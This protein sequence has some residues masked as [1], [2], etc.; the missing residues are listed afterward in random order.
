M[1]SSKDKSSTEENSAFIKEMLFNEN[2][3]KNINSLSKA[4]LEFYKVSK[5]I[6]TN[7]ELLINFGKK[8]INI[9]ELTRNNKINEKSENF[10]INVRELIKTLKEIFNKLEINNKSQQI[11]LSNF[12]EDAKIIFK[13]LREN[14]QEIISIMKHPSISYTKKNISEQKLMNIIRKRRAN[15][16]DP[17]NKNNLINSCINLDLKD[18]QNNNQNVLTEENGM[19]KLYEKNTRGKSKPNLFFV[20]E[21]SPDMNYLNTLPDFPKNNTQRN[22]L[23]FNKKEL[24]VQKLIQ[25]NRILSMEL[26]KY[27]SFINDGMNNKNMYNMNNFK[28]IN[29]FIKDKDKDISQLKQEKYQT[30][31][32]YQK[33]V[34]KHN[35]EIVQLNQENEQIKTNSYISSNNSK[36]DFEKSIIR[37]MNKL[38][39]ENKQLKDNIE[40]LKM[41]YVHSYV[42]SEFNMNVDN[43]LLKNDNLGENKTFLNKII[44]LE[45]K[46]NQKQKENTELSSKLINL[47]K[48]YED[49]ISV[50][51]KK[52]NELTNNLINNQNKLIN[53]QKES[54]NKN[55]IKDS[56][57]HQSIKDTNGM[58]NLNSNENLDKIKKEYE[59]K[60][61]TINK[62]VKEL[63][64]IIEKVK[65]SESELNKQLSTLKKQIMEK[66]RKIKQLNYQIEE[67]KSELLTKQAEN[68]ILSDNI[69]NLELQN[70][71]ND[72]INN[73]DI[74]NK[75]LIKEKDINN[76]LTEELN[77]IKQ[78]NIILQ[79][80][81]LSKEKKLTNL[82]I[83]NNELEMREKE[84]EILKNENSSLKFE[85]EQF[86]FKNNELKE[87]FLNEENK[88]YIMQKNENEGLKQMIEKMQKEREK[89]DNELNMYKRENEKIKNQLI[90]LSKTLPEEYNELQKQYKSLEGKYLNLK[91]KNPNNQTS[92]NTKSEEKNEDKKDKELL[93]A[94]KE[95]EQ[96]KKKN[97]E[98]FTQLEDKE[99]NKNFYDNRSEDANKS[100]YEEEFDLRKMAKGARDK[101]RSQDVNIDYPGLQNYKEK[102]RELE[103]YYNSLENLVKKL[104]LTIQC[105]PKNKTYVNE[106]CKIVGFD[107]ETTNKIIT[108]KNKNFILGLFSK[109]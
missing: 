36:S 20:D 91:N 68:Q 22:I 6:Y 59:N 88:N 71:N 49:K 79:N 81:L 1:M 13:R 64:L 57:Q 85:N 38:M 95:I 104:L 89:D 77:K 9:D 65:K 103:F 33:E 44:I 56:L 7:K 61:S 12:F 25:Q 98:L 5:N 78:N 106:L 46:L 74:L 8:E 48:K 18:F 54:L 52:Y 67:L 83:I 69:T 23:N 76:N 90:R 109:Q 40:E 55:V 96:L 82:S 58:Q 105:N 41:R 102:V 29:I 100:N 53:L 4:I 26:A 2:F 43:Y 24:E 86:K 73:N 19:E 42:H 108:N 72:N 75:E 37:K 3:I 99:I 11:N 15:T 63:E 10:K 66:D 94:K 30:N 32:R 80:K 17:K 27:K 92:K 84:I 50:L 51:S 101:N 28:K 16:I 93:E 107:S 45:K 62:K 47:K 97:V 39:Q 21:Y 70:Q 35:T 34:N 87:C 14:R 31:N 60:I